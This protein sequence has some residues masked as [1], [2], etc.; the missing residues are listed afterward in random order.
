M[1]NTTAT[2]IL[3][4]TT[5][6]QLHE[7]TQELMKVLDPIER[8]GVF[9]RADHRVTRVPE[10]AFDIHRALTLLPQL[11]P[12]KAALKA[13]S[14]RYGAFTIERNGRAPWLLWIRANDDSSDSWT[15]GLQGFALQV[16]YQPG[17]TIV[18]KHIDAAL[19]VVKKVL[20]DPDVQ[21]RGGVFP[22]EV[23]H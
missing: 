13:D 14:P 15:F 10:A 17:D 3:D 8:W 20:L 11:L 23:S 5:M 7:P 6:A 19:A 2:L 12:G 4:A 22:A 1:P 21:L 9:G 16:G 18:S